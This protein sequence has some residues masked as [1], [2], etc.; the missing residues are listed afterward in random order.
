MG[1]WWLIGNIML[2]FFGFVVFLV[3]AFVVYIVFQIVSKP[4]FFVRKT[5]YILK[6]RKKTLASIPDLDVTLVNK[7][8]ILSYLSYDNRLL[9]LYKGPDKNGRF[10]VPEGI[11]SIDEH[12]F[13]DFLDD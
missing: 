9:R 13:D 6:D 8:H 12:A 1:I 4:L 10:C 3:L 11:E 2:L 5:I 7:R